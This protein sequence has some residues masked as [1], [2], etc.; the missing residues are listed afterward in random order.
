MDQQ[1]K[2]IFNRNSKNKNEEKCITH[3]K[4]EVDEDIKGEKVTKIR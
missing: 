2:E 1:S 3:K 4:K